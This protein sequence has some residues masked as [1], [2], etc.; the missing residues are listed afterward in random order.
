[1]ITVRLTGNTYGIKETLKGLGFRWD[2]NG[3]VKNFKDSEET[4]ANEIATR[5]YTEGVYGRVTKFINA[6]L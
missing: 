2:R 5:W 3:W 4:K 6:R 1:M